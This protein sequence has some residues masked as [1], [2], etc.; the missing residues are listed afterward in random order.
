MRVDD[1]LAHCEACRRLIEP[2]LETRAV[3]LFSD[4]AEEVPA[5][6]HPTFDQRAAFVDGLLS[7]NERKAFEDHIASCAQCGPLVADLRAFRNE[8]AGDLNRDL[9]SPIAPRVAPPASGV[10]IRIPLWAYAAVPAMLLLAI[11]AWVAW[12]S[13]SRTRSEQVVVTSP[14]VMPSPQIVAS[15][16]PLRA[17]VDSVVVIRDG[18]LS[19][20]LAADG[21]LEGADQWRPELKRLVENALKSGRLERSQHL[22]G[23]NRRG[24]SLMGSDDQGQKFAPLEPAG[25]VLLTDSPTFRWW[26]L[27]G[28]TA[29]VVEVYDEKFNPVASSSQLTGTAW[30]VPRLPR[31]RTYSW[32]VKAIKDGREFL[33]PR[34][35]APQAK[36]RILDE[37]T[38]GRVSVIKRDYPSSHLLQGVVFAEAGLLDDAERELK[39]AQQANPEAVKVRDLLSSLRTQRR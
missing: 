13:S 8:I 16:S 11:A 33:A 1:H 24:S 5:D 22:A 20:R 4:L 14:S 19:L 6:S 35:P 29:Y 7:G 37:A 10:R 17:D 36:F 25:R 34:P 12:K 30:S 26:K 23:L 18:G 27:N 28:A 31:G 9:D 39:A 3:M 2:A 38:A 21:R 32:Q 15:P